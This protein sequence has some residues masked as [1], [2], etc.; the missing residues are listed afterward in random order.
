LFWAVA[1][2]H[3]QCENK[4]LFHLQRQGFE[5]YAPR[6]KTIKVIRGKK[7]PVINFIFPRY[8][9]VWIIEQWHALLSTFGVSTLLTKTV[10]GTEED[11][12]VPYAVPAAWIAEMKMRERDGYVQLPQYRFRIGQTVEVTSGLFTGHHGL[13]QGMTSRM[14]EVVLLNSLGRVE[15]ASGC[16][17]A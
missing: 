4:A 15:L 1:T 5:C 3:P 12:R 8:L 2:T 10:P 16:S 14:R 9:F 17:V 11:I 13:Y 7:V 6:E